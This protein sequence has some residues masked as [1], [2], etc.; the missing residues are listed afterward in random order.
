LFSVRIVKGRVEGR[1][2]DKD[3]PLLEMD[4]VGEAALTVDLVRKKM[5]KEMFCRAANL[6]LKKG[7]F[8]A[9]FNT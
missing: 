3:L 7:Q 4:F 5:T 9:C 2:A 6:M 8:L 1:I